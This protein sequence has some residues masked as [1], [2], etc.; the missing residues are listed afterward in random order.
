MVLSC[1]VSEISEKLVENRDCFIPASTL[2]RY[3]PLMTTVA[4]ISLFLKTELHPWPILGGL[5]RSS[6]KSCV[7]AQ[8]KLV[9]DRQTNG[10]AEKRS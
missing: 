7:C 4:N 1:I 10:Q 2:Q 8:L 6:I 5:N 3:N 9:T